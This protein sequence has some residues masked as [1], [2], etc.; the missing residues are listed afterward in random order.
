ML[1][2]WRRCWSSLSIFR[3]DDSLGTIRYRQLLSQSLRWQLET[4]EF[5]DI[6]SYTF[7]YNIIHT[8]I[9]RR[10]ESDGETQNDNM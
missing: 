6:I 10:Y 9:S 2:D 4:T 7:R 1:V 5:L 3:E 8:L